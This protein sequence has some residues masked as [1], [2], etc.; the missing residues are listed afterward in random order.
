MWDREKICGTGFER[1]ESK[2]AVY[3][4]R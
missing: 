4:L 1:R 3:S 2:I